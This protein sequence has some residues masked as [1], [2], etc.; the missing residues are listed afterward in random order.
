MVELIG[1]VCIPKELVVPM[2]DGTPSTTQP[3]M[4]GGLII[5]GGK[6][7]FFANAGYELVTST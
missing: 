3:L 7:Y 2:I 5:S 1:D 4:S 6:L